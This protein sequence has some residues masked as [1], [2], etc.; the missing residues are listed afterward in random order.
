[1]D[2]VTEGAPGIFCYEHQL[3]I[4]VFVLVGFGYLLGFACVLFPIIM[5][6]FF[7]HEYGRRVGGVPRSSMKG[8]ETQHDEGEK[9]TSNPKSQTNQTRTPNTKARGRIPLI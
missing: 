5:L 3:T 4:G 6:C 1:M 9:N 7:F 2:R 8:K